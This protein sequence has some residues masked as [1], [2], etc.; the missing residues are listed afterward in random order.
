MIDQPDFEA[1]AI[2][3][4]AADLGDRFAGVTILKTG[5]VGKTEARPD[6][7][8]RLLP[9]TGLRID[10]RDLTGRDEIIERMAHDILAARRDGDHGL[11][12]DLTEYG[13]STAQAARFGSSAHARATSPDFILQDAV[14]RATEADDQRPTPTTADMVTMLDDIRSRRVTHSEG[15]DAA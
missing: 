9:R 10:R 6:T 14:E 12:V 8:Q 13:W 1:A 15:G 7:L 4:A 11:L 5:N 3:T 2:A